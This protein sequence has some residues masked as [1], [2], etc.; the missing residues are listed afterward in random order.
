[1]RRPV[2]FCIVLWGM[3]SG[4]VFYDE[5]S[6]DYVGNDD[7]L[8]DDAGFFGDDAGETDLFGEPVVPA[9]EESLEEPVAAEVASEP[10]PQPAAAA[11]PAPRA[12]APAPE[13]K[14]QTDGYVVLARKYRPQTFDDIV[15]QE[16]V[17]K[18]LRGAIATGQ[19]SHAYLFS[20]PRGTGKTSTAR[21]LAKAL[22]CQEN[23]PRPDPC[24]KCASCRSITA[25]SSLDVIEIDAASNTGVDNIRELKSGVVLAPFSR[26][27]VYIVDEVHMLSNQ[28]FNALLKTLEEPPPQVIFVLATTELHKVPET[29]I[30]RC[31][32]FMFK[33]FTLVELKSQLGHILDIETKQRELTVTP[34]DREK[35][36]ELVARSAEGGMRDAQ[37]TLDQVLVLSK[38]TVDFE[39]VRRFLGMADAEALDLFVQ[40]VHDRKSRDLLQ[41]ID[42]L[43]SEGQDLELFVKG[44]CEHMRD[45]LLV[46]CAGKDTSLINVSEDRAVAL[47]AMANALSGAF[48][49]NSIEHFLKVIGEMK[50]SGQPRIVLELAVLKLTLADPRSEIEQINNRLNAL[51]ELVRSGE[52]RTA[53]AAN[54]A[55]AKRDARAMASPAETTRPTASEQ[56]AAASPQ[57]DAADHRE[58]VSAPAMGLTDAD[59][60]MRELNLKLS[61]QLPFAKMSI[62][63][64]MQAYRVE[65]ETLVVELNGS[66]KM[67]VQK[68]LSPQTTSQ[69]TAVLREVMGDGATL[70]WDVL[71]NAEPAAATTA[72]PPAPASAP[73]AAYERK[74][75]PD[76]PGFEREPRR[77]ETVVQR[78]AVTEEMPAL[79][80]VEDL[81][82]EDRP[83]KIYYTD[84][85]REKSMMELKKEEFQKRLEVDAKLKSVVDKAREAFG[86]DES[87][88]KFLRSTFAV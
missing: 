33:R 72:T 36:L 48:L 35:I 17:Q 47:S 54:P 77:S 62:E 76:A 6:A 66:Q 84:E 8:S 55:G 34:E 88:V 38:G 85:L 5:W 11:Q 87:R 22:N 14:P 32:T 43:A 79:P 46:Q 18:A 60:I 9:A 20:G 31:Q 82:D 63:R 26:Y 13:A 71:D 2:F 75:A 61:V 58:Q 10:A 73:A 44:A 68:L 86:I 28:A 21:I 39:S 45:L 81:M 49:V 56:A 78:S 69:M 67:S 83:L 1:M 37:V 74:A 23:G 12:A 24:G 19:I 51:E 59:E 52:V 30:S 53:P 80:T 57:A 4:Y 42:N 41:L 29:I 64:A 65:G 15:G 50:T 7:L 40:L 3:V 25:G 70:K 27:K 16:S